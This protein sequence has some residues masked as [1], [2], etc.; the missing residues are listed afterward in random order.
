MNARLLPVG[1]HLTRGRVIGGSLL[2]MLLVT[3]TMLAIRH[4]PPLLTGPSLTQL[5]ITGRLG[6][7]SPQAVREAVLSSVGSGFF[8]TDVENVRTAVSAVPWV[9][10][11]SVRRSW[12]HT[13]FVD[14]TEEIPVAHWN[15][16]DLMDAQGRVFARSGD[17]AWAKLPLLSGPQGS[18]TD[19]LSEYATYAVLLAPQALAIRQLTVDAR[20]DASLRLSD[21]I[22]VRLGRENAEPRLERFVSVVL[23]TLSSRLAQIAYVD[24]RY[25]NG[26]AV[27]FCRHT[28]GRAG[29]HTTDGSQPC[30]PDTE[31]GPNG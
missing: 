18:E 23:P 8:T 4:A 28:S 20:G 24:M 9:A 11:A 5:V 19:V 29:D 30:T 22:E 31:V 25:T 15:G 12:P 17:D 1:I 3:M 21:G 26:F 14:I 7:V 13:L 16:D 10:S 6:H 2:A 27:S